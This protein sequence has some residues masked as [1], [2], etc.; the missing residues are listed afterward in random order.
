MMVTKTW[1]SD[2]AEIWHLTLM[3]LLVQALNLL[4]HCCM[5]LVYLPPSM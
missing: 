2:M 1:L 4:N 5:V 3:Q